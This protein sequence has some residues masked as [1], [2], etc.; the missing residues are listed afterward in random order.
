MLLNPKKISGH[1]LTAS[2]GDIGTVKDFYFDDKTWAVRY[3]VADTGTWLTEPQVL[4][5][6][7]AF[8]R[9]DK[10]EDILHANL[11]RKQIESSPSIDAHRPVSRQYEEN[12]DNYYGWPVYW[13]GGET[14]GKV[15]YP[16]IEATDGTI[17]SVSGFVVDDKRWVIHELAVEAGTGIRARRS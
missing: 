17:G 12:Y 11:T 3:L 15:D 10:D 5:S 2:D 7:Y 8:G 4:P 13:Q 16:E 6:P 14:W 1:K 9:F